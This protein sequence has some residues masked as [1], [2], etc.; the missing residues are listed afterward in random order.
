MPN[1]LDFLH[2]IARNRTS[3][4]LLQP[5]AEQQSGLGCCTFYK[6]R[7]G[8]R[9]HRL[10]VLTR[11]RVVVPLVFGLLAWLGCGIAP[12]SARADAPETAPSELTNLLAEVDAAANRQDL[13]A[14]MQFFSQ[15]FTHADGL[16]H[17]T[18]EQA[19]AQTWERYSE[20]TYQTQLLSWERQE[21]TLV[22]ETETQITGVQQLGE[23]DVALEATLRSRQRIKDEKIVYQ[24]MLEE[25]S[26][27]TSGENPPSVQ[28]SAPEQVETAQSYNFDAIVQE[29]L[30][31]DL[32][33]G[34]AID[35]PIRGNQY[36]TAV[37][38]ELE[39]LSSGGLFK[40]G[41]APAVQDQRWLSA[42]FVRKGGIS[43]VTQRLRVLEPER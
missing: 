32:L 38:I 1:S 28:L 35:E 25:R 33:L 29:P 23:R 2:N 40:V 39:A 19:L 3:R 27:L 9:Q 12:E 8:Q 17:E 22:A 31:D 43:I 7:W 34:A 15:D 11:T 5:E 21:D 13:G 4:L 24:E 26:Q 18:F 20:M 41:R 37:P 14:V 30:D 36:F 10:S 16:N 6:H 42:M